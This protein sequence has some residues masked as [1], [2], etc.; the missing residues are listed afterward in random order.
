M[1]QVTLKFTGHV[2][3]RMKSGQMDFSFEGTTLRELLRTFFPQH[4]VQDLLVDE[5]DQL[6]PYARIVVEGR[7]SEFVGGLDAPITSG[8]MVTLINPYFVM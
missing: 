8:N 2:R 3:S 6:K 7:F 1:T 5:R 4:D